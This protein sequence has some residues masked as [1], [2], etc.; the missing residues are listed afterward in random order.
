MKQLLNK[1]INLVVDMHGCPNRCLH[2]WLGD[3]P[4]NL[5]PEAMDLKIVNRFKKYFNDV[6]FYSWLR[7]PDFFQDYK[8][9]WTRDNELSN[10]KPNR[11]ELASFYKIVRDTN[12]VKF[13]HEVGT[14]KVQ[15]TF[16]GME[17][18]TDKYIGRKGAFKELL[19]ATT[20]LQENNISPRW[21]IFIN[22]EN[23]DEILDVI[24][25]AKNNN[26][27]DIFIHAGSCDG[28][29]RKLYD[30][31]INKENISNELIPYYLDYNEV[32]T[33]KECY[34]LLEN[35]NSYFI[36]DSSE[37]VINI[38]SDYNMYFNYTNP[39]IKWKIGNVF[40]DNF[41]EIVNRIINKDIEAIR[42]A[43]SI[44]IKDLVKK[45][46]NY[47]SNKVFFLDDYKMYLL[48]NELNNN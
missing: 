22:E 42:I 32:L 25:I 5:I 28:N 1:H 23:K 46:G 38:T 7:E 21:Q 35:D 45:Y 14:K 31:R 9:R 40:D 3:V 11:F 39:S 20:I 6:T 18:L 16:F 33:E 12:Y 29:N 8:N 10:T 43:K 26:V 36:P 19:L 27:K 44:P 47:N 37:L 48:N 15:L 24:H 41:E 2:C 30:I 34:K 4:N 17:E 13:L